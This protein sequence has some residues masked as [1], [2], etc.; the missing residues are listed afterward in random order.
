MLA[1]DTETHRISRPVGAPKPVC[2]SWADESRPEGQ[3]RPVDECKEEITAWLRNQVLV[4][5]NVAFDTAVLGAYW[6]DLLP[7]IFRAYREGRIHD[8]LLNQK[9]LDIASGQMEFR[10]KSGGGYNLGALAQRYKIDGVD[11]DD[12]FRLKYGDLDTIP[13][14][15]WPPDAIEYSR[16]DAVVTLQIALKQRALDQAWQARAGQ[17]IL[18]AHAGTRARYDFALHLTSLHGLR[19]H[20]ARV[21]ALKEANERRLAALKAK[22]MPYKLVRAC[23]STDTKVAMERMLAAWRAKGEEVMLTKT[24]KERWKVDTLPEDLLRAKWRR[25]KDGT[26]R[27]E[28]VACDRDATILSG[29]EVMIQY[30]EYIRFRTLTPRIED[31]G[32]GVDLPLQ[33]R[34]DSLMETGRSSASS[35]KPKNKSAPVDPFRLVGCQIQNFPRGAGPRQCLEPRAGN[36]FV[37]A[38]YESAEL[39][40]LAQVCKKLFGQS[41]LGDLLN[42]GVDVHTW[43]AAQALLNC[44]YEE[45]HARVK[46]KDPKAKEARQAS[47]AII[48]GVPGGMGPK[49]LVLT[50]R[51]SYGVKLDIGLAKSLRDLVLRLLP[52]LAKYF[53]WIKGQL[54]RNDTGLTCHPITGFYRGG[55]N[56]SAMA[57]HQFQHLTAQGALA[58]LFEVLY[59]CYC[60]E[61]SPL[62]GFRPVAFCHDEIVLEGP[63]ERCDGAARRLGEVMEREMNVWTPDYPTPAEG[64]AMTVW[65]KDAYRVVQEG[66]IVPWVPK[67]A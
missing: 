52:E 6:P 48:Y 25:K 42:Q 45:A 51:K 53:E 60:C 17:P 3:V 65:D 61:D 58:A 32:K 57:N 8:T 33:P 7:L 35:G 16:K 44:T 64:V 5:Q 34:Y 56:Y 31:L 36:C 10:K 30:A 14:Q 40:S 24:A 54:G 27:M 46:A 41:K 50:A 66:R 63:V 18:A 62:Y 26:I 67:A 23:G 59:E 49:K 37:G 47:K 15:H 12:P 20:P 22:L 38:D 9:L 19:T 2:V 13:F 21:A 39:H 55:V 4:G 11:K 43:F 1:F 29:D 28:Y